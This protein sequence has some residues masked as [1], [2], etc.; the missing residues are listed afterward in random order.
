MIVIIEKIVMMMTMLHQVGLGSQSI[1]DQWL[2]Q[3]CCYT[4]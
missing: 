3:A 1:I 2:K 4:S